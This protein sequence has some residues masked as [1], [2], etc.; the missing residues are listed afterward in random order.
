[1]ASFLKK[2]AG[3]EKTTPDW[4]NLYIDGAS[5]VKGNMAGII[6]EG[7]DN[8]PLEQAL[9]LNYKASNNQAEYEALIT[10]L[11]LAREVRA[12]KLWRYTN[13]HLVKG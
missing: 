8:V 10:G 13:S 9:K 6:I 1:M 2:F 3:N 11:K 7:L 5:N 12:Q 4:L